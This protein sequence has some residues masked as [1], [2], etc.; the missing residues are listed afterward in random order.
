MEL[1]DVADPLAAGGMLF[2]S[3]LLLAR[4]VRFKGRCA[5]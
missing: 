4:K 5:Q 2:D 3:P 1:V